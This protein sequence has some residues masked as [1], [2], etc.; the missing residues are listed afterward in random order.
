MNKSDLQKII[1][2]EISNILNEGFQGDEPFGDG[3]SGFRGK[4]QFNSPQQ[5]GWESPDIKYSLNK[6]TEMLIEYLPKLTPNQRFKLFQR[7]KELVT[8]EIKKY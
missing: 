6:I 2:K 1:K 7:I 8:S 3:L 5:D 4:G